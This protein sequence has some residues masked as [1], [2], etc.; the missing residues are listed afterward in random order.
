MWCEGEKSN[1]KKRSHVGPK[2]YLKKSFF[3]MLEI[4]DPFLYVILAFTMQIT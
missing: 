3:N 4:F 1:T 2:F